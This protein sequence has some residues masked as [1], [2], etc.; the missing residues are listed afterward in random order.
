MNFLFGPSSV[1]G[2]NDYFVDK[3]YSAA[4]PYK[5]EYGNSDTEDVI[6][7]DS[8]GRFVPI[9]VGSIHQLMEILADISHKQAVIKTYNELT[10]SSNFKVISN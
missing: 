8:L 6:I 9:N 7:K 4:Y 3:N 1:V 5:V 2:D 10:N